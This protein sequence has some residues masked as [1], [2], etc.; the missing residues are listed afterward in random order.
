[1]ILLDMKGIVFPSPPSC[2]Y[3]ELMYIPGRFD[4]PSGKAHLSITGI[5]VSTDASTYH[6]MWQTNVI[7]CSLTALHNREDELEHSQARGSFSVHTDATRQC[8]FSSQN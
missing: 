8:A 3:D 4:D 2:L 6:D 1:M 5:Y 7:L